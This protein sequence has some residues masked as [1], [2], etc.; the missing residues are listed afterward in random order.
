MAAERDYHHGDL[1]RALVEAAVAIL[2]EDGIERLS[3]RAVA[4]RAGVSQAA[5]YHHFKDKATLLN[6]VAAEGFRRMTA[7]QRARLAAAG[8]SPAA[9]LQAFGIAYVLFAT[10][11][12][13]L[14]RLMF[15]PELSRVELQDS[16]R[17][18]AGDSYGMLVE[19]CTAV[20]AESDSDMPPERFALAAWSLVH[21]LS[22]LLIDRRSAI[23]ARTLSGDGGTDQ[24]DEAAV[25][26]VA[27]RVTA[28]LLRG[29]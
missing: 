11:H 2:E 6:E 7:L 20:L 14:F 15:G 27:E 23:I 22:H 12:P 5:P 8:G 24:D 29:P 28:V 10:R 21:G 25:E 19:G 9:H 26:A 1:A 4:R 3:L 17:A 16:F 18:E 13:G